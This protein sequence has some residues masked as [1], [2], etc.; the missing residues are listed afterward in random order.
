[1]CILYSV[2]ILQNMHRLHTFVK[3]LVLCFQYKKLWPFIIA[4]TKAK[5]WTKCVECIKIKTFEGVAQLDSKLTTQT[6]NALNRVATFAWN[7]N[8]YYSQKGTRADCGEL[9][10]DLFYIEFALLLP[11]FIFMV[12]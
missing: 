8:N 5:Q 1:M 2:N 6:K 3:S 10:R 4:L 9:G 11:L 7:N 12:I